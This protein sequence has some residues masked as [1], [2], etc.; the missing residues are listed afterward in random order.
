M[1]LSKYMLAY[2]FFLYILLLLFVSIWGVKFHNCGLDQISYILV[3]KWA[4]GSEV[5]CE[6]DLAGC[7]PTLTTCKPHGILCFSPGCRRMAHNSVEHLAQ[8]SFFPFLLFSSMVLSFSI[9]LWIS[10]VG[11]HMGE[12]HMFFVGI[13]RVVLGYRLWLV[14]TFARCLFW[15]FRV[16][17][18]H[19][20]N[21]T[22][23]LFYLS[24]KKYYNFS[25]HITWGK[26][27]FGRFFLIDVK[28]SADLFG[29]L[30][31]CNK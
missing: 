4:N 24:K 1:R 6:F 19:W 27:F 9:Y 8:V 12:V 30:W 2:F 3:Y 29:W 31:L 25:M 22:S 10:I 23:H 11:L 26:F 28:V 15:C 5:T 21:K 13:F 16:R 17:V 14:K 18:L 20:R 7:S